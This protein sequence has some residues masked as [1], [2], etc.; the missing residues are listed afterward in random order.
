MRIKW[1]ML[2]CLWLLNRLV[3]FAFRLRW[4]W[5]ARLGSRYAIYLTYKCWKWGYS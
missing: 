5:L 3:E 4:M 2:P 1:W